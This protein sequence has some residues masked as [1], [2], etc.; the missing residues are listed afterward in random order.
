MQI[1]M[2]KCACSD[3]YFV[4]KQMCYGKEKSNS[5]SNTYETLMK[6]YLFNVVYSLPP[7]LLQTF[8]SRYA[9][10][11]DHHKNI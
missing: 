5:S 2:L 6:Q 1:M 4:S 7:L 9:Y 11:A 3:K 8:L 10:G